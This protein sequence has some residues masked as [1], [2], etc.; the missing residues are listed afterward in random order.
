MLGPAS[1]RQHL[2]SKKHVTRQKHKPEDYE[3]VI[4]AV[5]SQAGKKHVNLFGDRY[6]A[7]CIAADTIFL[8]CQRCSMSLCESLELHFF[9]LWLSQQ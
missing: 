5:G 2:N 3:P 1:L 7:A 8:R 9:L 4:L 6:C